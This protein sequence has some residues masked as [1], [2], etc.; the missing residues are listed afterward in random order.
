MNR[1]ITRFPLAIAAIALLCALTVP[2]QAQIDLNKLKKKAEK[3]LP[4][5]QDDP[6]PAPKSETTHTEDNAAG[7]DPKDMLRSAERAVQPL[8]DMRSVAPGYYAKKDAAQN[9]YDEVK[10]ADYFANKAKAE[11]AVA[12]KPSLVEMEGPTYDNIVNKCPAAFR[13]L[14]DD[15]LIRE[16]NNAIEQAYAAKAKG[17]SSAGMALDHAEAAQLVAEAALLMQPDD[18]KLLG[19]RDDARAAVESMQKEYGAAVYTGSFHKEHAGQIVFSTSPIQTGKENPGAMQTSFTTADNIYGMMY[20]KGTFKEV[21]RQN[22]TG[23]IELLVDGTEKARYNFKLDGEKREQT[24]LSTEIIPDP[25]ISTT[26]GAAIFTKAIAE[27]SPR[28]HTMK[29]VCKDDYNV[30]ISEGEFTLDCSSGLD[31]VAAVNKKLEEK[32]VDAALVPAAGMRDAALEKSMVDAC[33]DW[34]E[35]PIKAI[36]TDGDWTIDRHP[37]TSAILSRTIN[38]TVLFKLKDGTCKAF[39]LSFRQQYKGKSY[40]KTERY[41]VGDSFQI[42]CDKVK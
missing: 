36:I 32:K 28:R 7:E 10:R 11:R 17:K 22:N 13:K 5:A 33:R 35:T 37:I 38:A 4:K 26:R 1:S 2:S 31:R 23:V 34:P 14:T 25:A 9:F 39:K 16:I 29:L 6:P 8:I 21:T 3:V 24:W 20:F 40:G 12:M 15:Y 30:P 42:S 19:L 41:G 18:A 27:L